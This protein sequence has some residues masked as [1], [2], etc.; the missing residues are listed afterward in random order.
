MTT[1]KADQPTPVHYNNPQIEHSEELPG[2]VVDLPFGFGPIPKDLANKKIFF[3]DIDNCL[4]NRSTQIHDLMQVKI[5][6]YFKDNLSLDDETAHEL[7]MNY[8]KTYGLAIEG[9]VRNHQ[10]DALDYN[11]KVDDSLDLKSVLSYNSDL[12]KMLIALKETHKFDYFWLITNAYK[13]HA[14]R[15]VSFLGVGDLFD[16]LTYCDY[17]KFPIICKPMDQFFYNCFKI[18][19]IDYTD[20]EVLAKQYFIDDSE[21]NV[22]AAHKLGFGNVIHYVEVDEDYEKIVKKEDFAE[23]YGKGDNTDKSKIRIIRD[24]LDLPKVL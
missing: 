19:Q 3:F 14:L 21:L 16:G 1:S 20:S 9:L 4:Y 24:I 7:H 11:S 12:R 22:K 2:T 8:Y 23:N 6:N 13:N 18:T 10:V 15:V 5:H 17:S